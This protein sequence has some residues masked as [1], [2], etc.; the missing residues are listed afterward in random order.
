MK[1]KGWYLGIAVLV[2]L[3][4]TA[5]TS[6]AG[7]QTTLA[8]ESAAPAGGGGG[9]SYVLQDGQPAQGVIVVGVGAASA[10]PEVAEITFGVE[11]RGDDPAAIVDEAARKIDRAMAAAREAGVAEEDIRTTGYSLWVETIYD[12][13]R[14]TPTGEVV[15]HVSHQL[16]ATLRDTGNVGDLLASVVSAGANAVSGVN[17]TVDDPQALVDQARQAAL[18]DAQGRAEAIA[19]ALDIE[20][21]QPTLVTEISGG[22]PV[23]AD[24]V[25]G[26]GGAGEAAAPSIVPGSFSVSVSVQVAY[27]IR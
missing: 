18:E 1:W 24:R 16:L 3:A 8:A 4:L 13:E 7:P 6:L 5:C 19:E 11:L 26:M 2:A 22:Y 23:F 21:G 10:E 27:E 20:L 15:Y 9:S 12:P 17:F 14:G 25:G